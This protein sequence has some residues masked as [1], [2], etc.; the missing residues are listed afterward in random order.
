MAPAMPSAMPL[1]RYDLNQERKRT[2]AQ[3]DAPWSCRC[4]HDTIYP[5]FSALC[6]CSS[7]IRKRCSPT[8][9]TAPLFLSFSLSLFI[10]SFFFSLIVSR[11]VKGKL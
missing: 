8:E 11:E 9:A 7:C 6:L 1:K 5:C 2:K 10:C 3:L 4:I